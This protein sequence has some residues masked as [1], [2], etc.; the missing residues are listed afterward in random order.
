MYIVGA[1]LSKALQ[2][3]GF[4]VPLMDD[5]I[6]VAADYMERDDARII[7]TS[8]R[9]LEE[10]GCFQWPCPF[11]DQD[12]SATAIS[13]YASVLR[14]RPA[15]NIEHLLA[16]ASGSA[17]ILATRVRYLINRLFVLLDWHVDDA[18]L[19]A[20][21]AA[22]CSRSETRHTFITFNYDLFLDRVVQETVPS[23]TV[24]AGYGI[25]V[26]GYV[27]A[28][29]EAGP[30]GPDVLPLS[31]PDQDNRVVLLK[32]HGS[33]N[34]LVPLA[35]ALP[36]GHAGLLFADHP[37]IVPLTKDGGLRYSGATSN[38][39]YVYPADALPVDVLP[40]IIPPVKKKDLGLPLFTHLLE[41]ERA[42]IQEADEIVIIGW[43]MPG[44]D[45]SQVDLIGE[46]VAQ[47]HGPPECVTVVNRGEVP[48]YFARIAALFG[49]KPSGLRVYNDGFSDFTTSTT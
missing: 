14:R 1:G 16:A 28:D 31:A 32:P 48:A 47:R 39:Q 22:Q 4:R 26:S 49:V 34:W 7:F 40:A 13:A 46:A 5:F 24:A 27:L 17:R 23:W 29:P 20:F 33:L 2:Q 3:P 36:M 19:R 21:L 6:S 43:S 12:A 37:P 38:F 11:P 15:E 45:T 25:T 30:P 10:A 41:A 9:A 18:L 44:T 42:A 35:D 8:I